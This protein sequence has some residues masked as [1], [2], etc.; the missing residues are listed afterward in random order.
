MTAQ[1]E[2]IV[3]DAHC[4]LGRTF[5]TEWKAKDLVRTMDACGIDRAVVFPTVNF[6]DNKFSN[7]NDMIAKAVSEYPD[8]LIGFARVNPHRGQEAVRELERSKEKLGLVG[9]KLHP[10]TE[11]FPAN[12][13]IVHP[14]M[15]T[16]TKLGM[17]V[18]FH[19]GTPPYSL[20]SQIADVAVR[21]SRI[22]VVMAHMG[23]AL[24][25]EAI[26]SAKRS[27]NVI[28]ETSGSSSRIGLIE[29]AVRTLGAKRIIFGSDWPCCHPAPEKT[30]IEVLDLSKEA[31]EKILGR[32]LLDMLSK[33][34]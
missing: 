3:V 21:F 23:K 8:R 33:Y 32:N 19:S 20:P 6:E 30:K 4:H 10:T 26:S 31:K 15:K 13:R 12:S 22:P 5:Q 29:G 28:L 18:V 34:R 16:A 11:I 17:P 27:K 25:T 9:I 24:A 1:Q 14:I 2:R 7:S